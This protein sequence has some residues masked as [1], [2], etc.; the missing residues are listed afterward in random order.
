MLQLSLTYLQMPVVVHEFVL[1]PVSEE[2]LKPV[3][4]DFRSKIFRALVPPDQLNPRG[5]VDGDL[6]AFMPTKVCFLQ[7]ITPGSEKACRG[8][9]GNVG[10]MTGQ[11]LQL[12]PLGPAA[13]WM[14]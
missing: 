3:Q 10:L 4:F 14:L 1:G 11:L 8:R 7:S 5:Y 12:S 13:W 2:D 6:S 9:D